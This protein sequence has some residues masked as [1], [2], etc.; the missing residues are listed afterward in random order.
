MAAHDHEIHLVFLRLE[1]DFIGGAAKTD[2]EL[3]RNGQAGDQFL[4]LTLGLAFHL[5]GDLDGRHVQDLVA[6]EAVQLIHHVDQF[7]LGLVGVGHEDGV[8]EYRSGHLG[9]IDGA[10]QGFDGWHENLPSSWA[11]NES[12][13]P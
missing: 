6:V 11:T 5:V 1:D 7:E 4:E 13:L 8:V 10:E 2:L 9:E 3:G 12:C